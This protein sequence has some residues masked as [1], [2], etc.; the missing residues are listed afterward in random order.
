MP[1]SMRRSSGGYVVFASGHNS[2][3]YYSG[4]FEMDVLSRSDVVKVLQIYT[5]TAEATPS[6]YRMLRNPSSMQIP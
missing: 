3:T 6:F 2:P 4:S 5:D 1:R